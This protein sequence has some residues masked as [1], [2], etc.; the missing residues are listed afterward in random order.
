VSHP[1]PERLA[2]IALGEPAEPAERAHLDACSACADELTDLAA[3]VAVGRATVDVGEL[4]TP[5]ERVWEGIAAEISAAPAEAA[6]PA[7]VATAAPTAARPSRGRMLF[8][9]AASVAVLAGVVGAGIALRP[10]PALEVAEATLDPFPAHP[11]ARG[12]AIVEEDGDR[13]VVTVRLE[14]AEVA[15]GYREVWLITADASAL[16]S[17][18]VLADDE[19]EFDVPPGIDLQEYVL[20]DVSVESEDGDPGHSGDSIVRGELRSV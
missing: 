5:P 19:G 15:D 3:A 6:P 17:L 4:E 8:A 14:D 1:D 16:V 13:R 7:P 2:L 11:A 10:T 9:L 12:S 20:V 18:G